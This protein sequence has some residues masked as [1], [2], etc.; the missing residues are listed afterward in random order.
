MPLENPRQNPGISPQTLHVG[1]LAQGRVTAQRVS[2]LGLCFLLE[3]MGACS[4]HPSRT[5][6]ADWSSNVS[7]C[8]LWTTRPKSRLFV[9]QWPLSGAAIGSVWLLCRKS[10]TY[11]V[12]GWRS[13]LSVWP[14]ISSRVM[15]LQ[16]CDFKPHVGL[17]AGSREPACNSLSPLLSAPPRLTLSLS[18]SNN[19]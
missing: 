1:G 14:L 15:I 18:L 4:W 3:K 9:P 8:A 19:F 13:W 7:L 5:A 6:R 10:H 2:T 16:L 11:E 17:C 12:P